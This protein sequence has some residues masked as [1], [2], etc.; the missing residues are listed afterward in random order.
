MATRRTEG[1]LEV[2]CAGRV[3]VLDNYRKLRQGWPGFGD[4]PFSQTRQR[5][6]VAAFVGA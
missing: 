5:A 6:C 1:A 3:L 2:F 4:A